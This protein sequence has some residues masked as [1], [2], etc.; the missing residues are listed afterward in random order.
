MR[1]LKT[2]FEC[3]FVW[4]VRGDL[5][6]YEE[7][8]VII[9]HAGGDK[10]D[11]RPGDI[12]MYL[13]KIIRDI[14]DVYRLPIIA[15]G[16]LARCLTDLRLVGNIPEQRANNRYLSTVDVAKLHKKICAEHF[17]NKPLIVSYQPHLWRAIKVSEKI[18]LDVI[19]ANVPKYVFESKCSQIWLRHWLL[20]AI[21]E[22][23]CRLLWLI[24]GKI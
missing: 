16:E 12:N 19:A 22:I 10:I 21:R 9:A 15:Q 14:Y 7:A 2:L 17:W 5:A 4:H 20:N 8:D 3:F 18:G 13:E 24:Q 23:P 1:F 11:G 6:R